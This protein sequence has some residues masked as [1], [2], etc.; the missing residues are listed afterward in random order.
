MISSECWF[1]S[2][3]FEQI[4]NLKITH[5][6]FL[7]FPCCCLVAKSCSTLCNPMHCSLPGFSVRGISQAGIL[8]WVAMSFSK[9]SSRPR[10]WIVSPILAGRFFTA[11][12]RSPPLQKL[13]PPAQAWAAEGRGEKRGLGIRQQ[14]QHFPRILNLGMLFSTCESLFAHQ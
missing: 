12:P 3:H 8:E 5:A 11:E 6:L 7:F 9:I 1:L 10:D 2:A 14:C 4:G 13:S